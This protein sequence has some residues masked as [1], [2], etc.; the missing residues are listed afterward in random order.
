[1]CAVTKGSTIFKKELLSNKD[2]EEKT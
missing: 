1:M 2:E